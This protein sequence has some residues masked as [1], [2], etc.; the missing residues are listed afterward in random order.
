MWPV[1]QSW[2]TGFETPAKN[3]AEE[4][5]SERQKR[6]YLIGGI[7]EFHSTGW[8]EEKDLLRTKYCRVFLRHCFPRVGAVE[9]L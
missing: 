7:K 2:R 5:F 9:L 3:G 4:N 6:R 1:M 8:V